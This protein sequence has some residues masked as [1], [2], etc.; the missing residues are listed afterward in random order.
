M[1]AKEFLADTDILLRHLIHINS[2]TLSE[3]EFAMRQGVVFT[4]VINASELYFGV[5]SPEEKSAVDSLLKSLKIL[6]I[7]SRYSLNISDFF[8]KVADTRDALICVVAKLNK[9]PILT[10]DPNRYKNS[11]IEIINP[12][13]LRG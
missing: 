8:N 3:L 4:T 6:G 12:D 5:S 11:G 13:E 9:L 7:N 1:K 10:A 2:S